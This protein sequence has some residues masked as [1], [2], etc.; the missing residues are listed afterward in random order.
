[1]I[2][3]RL[4]GL[5]LV[6][7]PG[8]SWPS[9][10]LEWL[11]RAVQASHA[12][13]YTGVYVYQHGDHVEMLQVMQRVDPAG[14]KNKVEVI[15]GPHRVFLR[16]NDEIYCHSADGKTVRLERGAARRFFP[17]VLPASPASL[18]DFYS[19]QMGGV[20][21]I[22]ARE[23]QVIVLQPK[24]DFR[25][26]HDLCIDR[27]TGLPL[28]AVTLNE[29]GRPVSSSTFTQVDIGKI[30][31]IGLFVPHLAG[32]RVETG[33]SDIASSEWK[34]TPPPGYVQVM[35]SHRPLLGKSQ[36]VTQMVFSDGLGAVSLFIEPLPD[37]QN[38]EG[39]STEGSIGIYSRHL[40]NIKVTTVGEAPA[41]TL[42]QTGNS[43][44]PK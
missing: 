40:G 37:G 32:K 5:A 12:L 7:A 38:L 33:A 17:T 35:E 29:M 23:C 2:T 16:L 28:K 39:L 6:L 3:A 24:D 41:A 26:S 31:D 25:F 42:L 43:V 34:V 20:E 13:S 21:R 14:E 19:A 1:M 27:L 36:P 9:D 30:P 11:N 22:A 44:R 8:V 4:L 18:L 15:D 10:A